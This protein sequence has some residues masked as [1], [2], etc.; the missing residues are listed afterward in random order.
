MRSTSSV[1]RVP[2]HKPPEASFQSVV[3]VLNVGGWGGGFPSQPP[4][5]GP[6]LPALTSVTVAPLLAPAHLPVRCPCPTCLCCVMCPHTP[7]DHTGNMERA[8]TALLNI[9]LLYDRLL[10]CGSGP[11]SPEAS[12]FVLAS[13][14]S[15][16]TC[17]QSDRTAEGC[18][19]VLR[20][21]LTI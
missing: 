3:P 15:T 7:P 12:I 13:A 16:V 17:Q 9:W 2:R 8:S 20:G 6:T 14:S 18:C 11:V 1:T 5:P 10:L 4:N 21:V 19:R